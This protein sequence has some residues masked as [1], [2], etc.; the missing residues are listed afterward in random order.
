MNEPQKQRKSSQ[1]TLDRAKAWAAANP[2]RRREI[3]RAHYRRQNP[4]QKIGL[5]PLVRFEKLYAADPSTGCWLWLGAVNKDGYG[6]IK[7]DRKHLTAHRWSWVLHKGPIPDGAHVL[8]HCDVPGCVNPSHLFIGSNADNVADREGKGRGHKLPI[9]R[10]AKLTAEEVLEIRR[11][12]GIH[13]NHALAKR[14][15]V[16]HSHISRLQNVKYWKHL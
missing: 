9:H 1:A 15:G 4:V 16:H 7:V 5:L 14:F 10:E 13:T 3:Q 2:E 8:H 11:L 12:K 6:K